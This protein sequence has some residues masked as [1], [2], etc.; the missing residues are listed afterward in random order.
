M[1]KFNL[2]L[3]FIS[4][5]LILNLLGC[6][7]PRPVITKQQINDDT[8]TEK[9]DAIAIY[10]Q[11]YPE[12]IKITPLTSFVKTN[13]DEIKLRVYVD[14][15]DSIGLQVRSPAVFRFELYQHV[16]QTGASKG[17]R[18]AIWPDIDLNIDMENQKYWK[19]FLRSYEFILPFPYPTDKK[20][21]LQLNCLTP[22]GKRIYTELNQLTYKQ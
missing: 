11:Y 2:A 5:I 14:M 21:I 13:G 4:A 1:K 16:Q 6:E 3:S 10:S 9:I 20:Y 12:K 18:V 15:L 22:Y 8:N 19:D 17:E 7:K